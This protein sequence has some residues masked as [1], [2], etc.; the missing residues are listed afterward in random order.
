MWQFWN[1]VLFLEDFI[2]TRS[3]YCLQTDSFKEYPLALIHFPPTRNVTLLIDILR[4]F[5]CVNNTNFRLPT[6]IKS[7]CSDL[8]WRRKPFPTV[9]DFDNEEVSGIASIK[10]KPEH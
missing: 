6:I 9:P 10:S 7:I 8:N 2:K 3:T 4:M 5:L 1:I